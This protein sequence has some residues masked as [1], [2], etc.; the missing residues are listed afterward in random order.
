MINDKNHSA[1]FS[2]H[3]SEELLFSLENKNST[4]YIKLCISIEA[5]IKNA[6]NRGY[7]RYLCGMIKGFDLLCAQAV[8]KIRQE[9]NN[10]K[11]I[12][13]LPSKNDSSSDGW[14]ELY[15]EVRSAADGGF[16]SSLEEN[17]RDCYRVRNLLMIENSSH[18][19]CYWNGQ[20]G[21]TSELI[22]MAEKQGHSIDNLYPA[23]CSL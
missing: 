17:A 10:I 20:S 13:I 14:G 2:G 22:R 21:R 7:R 9:N 1:C 15:R 19:I 8:L 4:E 5:A 3:M 11:L 18:I 6:M 23:G 12:C 16:F